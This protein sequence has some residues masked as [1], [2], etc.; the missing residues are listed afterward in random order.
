MSR[1][2]IIL[3]IQLFCYNLAFSQIAI[4]SNDAGFCL[5]YNATNYLNC[6]INNNTVTNSVT[7]L[8]RNCTSNNTLVHTLNVFKNYASTGGDLLIEFDLGPGIQNLHLGNNAD[9]DYIRLKSVNAPEL[10]YLRFSY[11]QGRFFLDSNDFFNNFPK[12]KTISSSYSGSFIFSTETPSFTNLQFLTNL[13]LQLYVLGDKTLT[14]DMVSGLENLV[15]LDLTNSNFEKIAANALKGLSNLTTLS[16]HE[17]RIEQ[18]DDDVFSDLNSLED[19]NLEG[20]DIKTASVKAF[21]GLE[22]VTTV[23]LSKNPTFSLENILA[24]KS[25]KKLY[26][27][28]NGYTFLGPEI[29]QQLTNL[30]ILYLDNPFN[31]NCKMQ[32]AAFV[33]Q[34]GVTINGALC[35]NPILGIGLP[36]T[37]FELYSEC[38]NEQFSCFNKS[39]SCPDD[40]LCQNT[41]DGSECICPEGYMEN[42]KGN[43]EDRNECIIDN[44]GCMQTCMNTVGGYECLCK[45]GYKMSRNNRKKCVVSPTPSP[46]TTIPFYCH[47]IFFIW[48]LIVTV[49]L[50]LACLLFPFIVRFC[51][52]M[53]VKKERQRAR[54][55]VSVISI[56]NEEESNVPSVIPDESLEVKEVPQEKASKEYQQ[57]PAE[58]PVD[59]PDSSEGKGKGYQQLA[60][61]DPITESVENTSL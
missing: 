1:I 41:V 58:E 53:K 8:L 57:L 4:C 15:N 28:N 19:L 2:Y 5:Q 14:V 56:R 13:E 40:K 35:E 29:L 7:A 32:W 42:A 23:D 54:K 59:V 52:F 12:L 36:I 51:L 55:T 49:I 10:T 11:V 33:S 37:S 18:L 16:L 61:E 20:N 3:F 27:N 38:D 24:F 34:Y 30:E 6:Y 43:C 9:N 47:L 45:D 44:G 50:V 21:D 26:L 39:I 46:P 31:C 60:S 48:A 25:V 22:N 17:N